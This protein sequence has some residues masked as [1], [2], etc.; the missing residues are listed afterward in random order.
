MNLW[1]TANFFD[2]PSFFIVVWM[3]KSKKPILKY[4]IGFFIPEMVVTN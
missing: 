1:I 3:P 2:N 4:R